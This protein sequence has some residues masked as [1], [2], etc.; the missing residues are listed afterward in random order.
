MPL[1]EKTETEERATA[2]GEVEDE[3]RP[4]GWEMIMDCRMCNDWIQDK[5]T[6]ASFARQMVKR[7]GMVA[8]GDPII[9]L[10]GEGNKRGYTLVQL[11]TTSSITAHF[12]EETCDAYINVFSCKKFDP[13]TVSD[14]VY[15]YFTPLHMKKACIERRAN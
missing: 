13:Q 9:E 12:C 5:D 8:H 3:D 15:E 6:I 14:V 11:I 2:V 7:I 4:W 1:I 10:F